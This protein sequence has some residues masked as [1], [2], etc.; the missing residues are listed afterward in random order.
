ML[1]CF[2][3]VNPWAVNE[4]RICENCKDVVFGAIRLAFYTPTPSNV[5]TSNSLKKL[6]Q[7]DA[8]SKKVFRSLFMLMLWSGLDCYM[9]D[10]CKETIFFWLCN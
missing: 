6:L 4:L 10:Q 8:E 5:L 9:I 2:F 3:Y 7:N 1:G